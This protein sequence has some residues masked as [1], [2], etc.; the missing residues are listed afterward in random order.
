MKAWITTILLVGTLALLTSSVQAQGFRKG[1]HLLGVAV[2]VATDPVGFGVN[3]E[4]GVTPEVGIGG[5]LRYW[6]KSVSTFGGELNWSVIM[7][8]AQ[9]FYHFMPKNEVD[10][11]VGG[12]LGYAIYS[13][14]WDAK[15]DSFLNPAP[16]TESGGLF[17]TGVGGVRYF[18]SPKVAANASLE[19]RIAGTD[20]FDSG[21][22]LIIGV[23][24]VL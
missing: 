22:G 14:S 17:L 19:F 16:K 21:I 12:R 9:V 15:G 7:P 1:E 6:G 20:Y 5:L 11:Y 2:T 10:P 4:Y 23:D 8:Q 18:F 3:Y 24:F 13:T